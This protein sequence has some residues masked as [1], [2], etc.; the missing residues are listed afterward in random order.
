MT[1]IKKTRKLGSLGPRKAEIRPEKNTHSTKKSERKGLKPGA[2]NAQSQTNFADAGHQ[3]TPKDERIGSKTP[4]SL[5]PEP[6][7][8]ANQSPIHKQPQAKVNKNKKAVEPTQAWQQELLAL[9]DNE[10]LQ[11]LLTRYENDEKLTATELTELNKKMARYAWLMEKLG[12]NETPQDDDEA[13]LN[14]WENSQ[15]E[16][17]DF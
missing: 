16:D 1:R 10:A 11:T 4:I 9:E 7:Q 13:L 15:L 2:R 8:T 17:K 6:A 5:N 3:Q 12:L 14:E